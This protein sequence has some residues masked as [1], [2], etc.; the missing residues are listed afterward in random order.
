VSG[1]P[2]VGPG[3][4]SVVPGPTSAGDAPAV[5][6]W[7]EGAW[8]RASRSIGDGP[9]AECS[10]VVWLQVGR[11]FAD[12]RLPRPG[13]RARHPFD[14]AQA[15]SGRLAV[16]DGSGASARVAWHHDLDSLAGDGGH[17][18][19]PDEA[20]VTDRDGVLIESGDGYVEWWERSEDRT[21]PAR[22]VVLEH[23]TGPD[24]PEWARLVCVDG[25]AVAVWAGPRPG[26]AWTTAALGWEPGR[27]VGV[28]PDGLDVGGAVRA[29]LDGGAPGGTWHDQEAR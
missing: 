9:P 29:R 18:G 28:P 16:L 3:A 14:E 10:D 5:P 19:P 2:G 26:G 8:V 1:D 24:D 23:G 4:L 12:L 22:G 25:M 13:R 6:G 17:V 27:V 11:W 7:L 15:F 21:G 20:T